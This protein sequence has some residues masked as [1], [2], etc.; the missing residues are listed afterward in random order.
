MAGKR[1][2]QTFATYPGTKH[3]AALERLDGRFKSKG[4]RISESICES[5]S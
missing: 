3:L 2:M 5:V 1:R 4:K